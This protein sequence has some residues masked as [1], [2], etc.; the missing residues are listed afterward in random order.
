MICVL[1]FPLGRNALALIISRMS[2]M[3]S[4]TSI[5]HPRFEFSPG[6]MIQTFF[7]F[8]RLYF[9]LVDYLLD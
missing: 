9:T 6:L 3:V 2:S 4:H 5:P 8:L 7:Y 1:V